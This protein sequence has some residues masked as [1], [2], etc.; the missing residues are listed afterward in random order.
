MRV[1]SRTRWRLSSLTVL[2]LAVVLA[3]GQADFAPASVTQAQ[4]LEPLGD[5]GAP[6]PRSPELDAVVAAVESAMAQY[7]VPG[8]MIGIY[9]DGREE[10]AARIR[11]ADA[12]A[13]ALS[14]E[15][16]AA[17]AERL[18]AR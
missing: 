8:A 9:V 15:Q 16:F 13:E 4:T 10:V 11:A 18:R 3:T 5:T 7:E 14:P 6:P 2:A 17:L 12:R 1:T